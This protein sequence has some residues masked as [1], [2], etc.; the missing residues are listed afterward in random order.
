[1]ELALNL[2]FVGMTVVFMSL[3]LLSL[4]I[5][6][7][8]KILNFTKRDQGN[9]G[10]SDESSKLEIED[11][12]TEAANAPHR[13]ELLAVITAA[14]MAAMKDKP[15]CEIRVKSFRRI[16]QTTPIW[17]LAGRAEHIAGKL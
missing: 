2:T 16:T 9:G 13:A 3:L 7:F 14:V 17:N 10:N 12:T 4:I 15:G 1:M 8:S 11:E 6:L 5:G